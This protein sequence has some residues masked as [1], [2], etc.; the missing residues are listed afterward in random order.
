[1]KNN[2]VKQEILFANKNTLE[3]YN[4]HTLKIISELYGGTLKS[5]KGIGVITAYGGLGNSV[6]DWAITSY[7]MLRSSIQDAINDA[8]IKG[9]VFAINSPGGMASG[10]FET[11]DLIKS[12]SEVKPVFAY[13]DGEACSAAYALAS[14]CNRIYISAESIT[15]CCGCYADVVEIDE[16]A[17]TESGLLHRIFRSKNAPKKNLSVI[18]NEDAQKA[19]QSMIDDHGDHYLRLVALNRGVEPEKAE[20]LFG[21]GAVVSAEYA[22]EANMVDE[23]AGLNKCVSD[24]FDVCEGN[25]QIVINTNPEGSLQTEESEGEAMTLENFNKMSDEEKKTFVSDLQSSN[26]SLFAERDAETRKAERTRLSELNG[27]RNGSAEVDAIVNSAVEDGRN[28]KDIALDVIEAMKI[29]KPSDSANEDA[30][31]K[32]L[33]AMA[34][35]DEPANV[36]S[37]SDEDVM[38]KIVDDINK[39]R[40][41][42]E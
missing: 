18:T 8:E 27:L 28:A 4:A 40:N 35:A 11:C 39:E 30:R 32:V 10:L 21:E 15:G 33:D 22:L 19:Y 38:G 34:D 1:M 20:W 7:E 16:K 12:L 3:N 41:G 37:V 17:Y 31:N 5:Y 2:E 14:V 13:I 29:A 42:N 9:V 23:I 26:P 24:L 36:P 25:R 6:F